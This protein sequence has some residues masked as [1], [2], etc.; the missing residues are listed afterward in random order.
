MS[1]LLLG[2]SIFDRVATKEDDYTQLLCNL[3]QRPEPE[4]ERL[5][6]EV[7]AKLLGDP[8]IASRVKPHQISTQVVISEIGRPDLVVESNEVRAAIEVKLNRHRRCTDPQMAPNSDDGNLEGYCR[9]LLESS[10]NHKA[11]V[12]AF[13]VP[14]DWEYLSEKRREL[15]AFRKQYPSVRTP[16]VL[17]EEIFGLSKEFAIDPLHIEFWKL[18]QADFGAVEFTTEEVQ[19]AVNGEGLPITVFNKAAYL[20]DEIAEKCK[21]QFPKFSLDGPK[22]DK[23]GEEYG[24]HFYRQEARRDRDKTFFFWFGIWS[25]FWGRHGKALCFGVRNDKTA[26]REAFLQSYSGERPVEFCDGERRADSDVWTLGWIPEADY[27][28]T[29]DGLDPVAKIWDWLKPL[30]DRVYAAAE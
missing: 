18:L 22:H 21:Q 7:L 15:A 1:G 14:G 5:R 8:A 2:K 23:S 28:V 27:F 29:D 9:F 11:K 6:T 12:L 4:G 25:A 19:M 24:I 20:V 17:W 3:M 16:V 13:L 30:L 10:A 26:E